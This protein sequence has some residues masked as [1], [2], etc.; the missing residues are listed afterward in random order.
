MHFSALTSAVASLLILNSSPKK[1][2][3][4]F[5]EKIQIPRVQSI[6]ALF[7]S[8]AASVERQ[9][10]P[11]GTFSIPTCERL[12]DT[13][14]SKI[15]ASALQAKTGFSRPIWVK[16]HVTFLNTCLSV[17][18]LGRFWVKYDQQPWMFYL[19]Q[20]GNP[21]HILAIFGLITCQQ[22]HR[23]VVRYSKFVFCCLNEHDIEIPIRIHT[24]ANQTCV[25]C[26]VHPKQTSPFSTIKYTQ[27]QKGCFHNTFQ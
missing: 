12:Q 15:T 21:M 25:I 8:S 18:F 24:I 7:Q 14:V 26:L 4:I 9:Q 13:K 10:K 1:L 23:V 19:K 27:Q 11:G 22:I 17:L 3:I 5:W 6:Y 20:H 16:V 2:Y